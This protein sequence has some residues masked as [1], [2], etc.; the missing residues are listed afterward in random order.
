MLF[1]NPTFSDYWNLMLS[2]GLYFTCQMEGGDGRDHSRYS[3]QKSMWVC[4]QM[5]ALLGLQY[6]CYPQE[7]LIADGSICTERFINDPPQ[8]P[9][10]PN[11]KLILPFICSCSSQLLAF[12]WSLQRFVLLVLWFYFNISLSVWHPVG[13]ALHRSVTLACHAMIYQ[14]TNPFIEAMQPQAFHFRGRGQ[15]GIRW[16]QS[17]TLAFKGTVIILQWYCRITCFHYVCAAANSSCHSQFQRKDMETEAHTARV[18]VV[19]YKYKY[20]FH[21]YH[22]QWNSM[23]DN[24]WTGLVL[25]W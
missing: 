24:R 12:L 21:V 9:A 16:N 18:S 17:V 20:A 6:P 23:P 13:V 14:Y 22:K 15:G 2:L 1:S 19:T 25:D 7:D 4:E 11:R 3:I 5:K 8:Q 10:A